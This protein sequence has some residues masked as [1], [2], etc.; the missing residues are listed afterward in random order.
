M[1]F[2][3]SNKE[4]DAQIAEIRRKIRL[5]M[6]GVV[7]EQMKISG[8]SYK[9]NFGVSIPRLREIALEYK[10][11]HDLCQRLWVLKIRETM[12]L[13]TLLQPAEKFTPELAVERIKEIDQ[14]E[15]VEQMCMNLLSKMPQAG[16]LILMLIQSDSLWLQ[17][18]G[19]MLTVRVY[20]RLNEAEIAAVISRAFELS[21]TKEFYLYKTIGLSLSRLCRRDTATAAFVVENIK[22]RFVS[23]SIAQNYIVNEVKL[24][25]DFLDNI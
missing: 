2:Y 23:D 12:I 9:N 3:I 11:N 20:S 17:I 4:L 21:D 8:I 1:N 19:F 13:S 6:N 16:E 14:M 15:M 7:S 5:S 22:I 18:T 24:E 10:P 25:T